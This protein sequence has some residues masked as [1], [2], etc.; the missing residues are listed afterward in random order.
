MYFGVQMHHGKGAILGG[1]CAPMATYL[2]Q[3]N[4]PAQRTNAFAAERRDKTAMR[5]LAKFCYIYLNIMIKC[6]YMHK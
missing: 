5:P 6:A 4:V 2:L 3:A 1:T